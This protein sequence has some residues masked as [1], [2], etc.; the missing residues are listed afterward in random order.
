MSLTE[1][2][3]YGSLGGFAGWV[4]TFALP[5]LR[6]LWSGRIQLDRATDPRRIL[7]ATL[8]AMAF[9]FSGGIAALF[10]SVDTDEPRNAIAYGAAF[11]VVFASV[12]KP[13]GSAE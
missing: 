13:S 9:T 8:I 6:D 10:L 3:L 5:H 4:V 7:L 2:F 12:V 11:E 1:G